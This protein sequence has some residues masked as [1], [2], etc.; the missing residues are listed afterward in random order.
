MIAK[1]VWRSELRGQALLT[2]VDNDSARH[3]L[4]SGYSP[5]TSS[6][7]LLSASAQLDAELRLAQ[8]VA[9]VPT[10]SNIA[11]A[12]SRLDVGEMRRIGAVQR[13]I[14]AEYTS[15]GWQAFVERVRFRV[16]RA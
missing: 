6:C 10:S 14:P 8:W 2:F 11:D 16:N 13:A 7:E 3:A 15:G 12:P 5:V 1:A 4:V 9:R